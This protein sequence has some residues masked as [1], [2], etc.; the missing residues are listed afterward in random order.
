[1]AV[2]NLKVSWDVLCE[3]QHIVKTL[4]KCSVEERRALNAYRLLALCVCAAKGIFQKAGGIRT[5]FLNCFCVQVMPSSTNHYSIH[6]VSQ[7]G[8][9]TRW[10]TVWKQKSKIITEKKMTVREWCKAWP[11]MEIPLNV[12]GVL[13]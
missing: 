2:W 11:A 9:G 4:S 7:S 6:A 12:T 5:E 10:R 13:V 1:M 8:G 3:V